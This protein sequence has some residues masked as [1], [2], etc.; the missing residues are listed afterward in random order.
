MCT[1]QIPLP[2][3]PTS[4]FDIRTVANGAQ[5]LRPACALGP[6]SP[7]EQRSYATTWLMS[8]WQKPSA[9]SKLA[10]RIQCEKLR[11]ALLRIG[12]GQAFVRL[13]RHE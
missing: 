3:H 12:H 6:H 2:G 8:A 11:C 5:V 4:L 9:R 13:R 10:S 1:I 7:L